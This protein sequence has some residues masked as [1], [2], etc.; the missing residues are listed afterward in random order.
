MV[1]DVAV[2]AVVAVV[3]DVAK[4]AILALVAKEADVIV[5]DELT[6]DALVAVTG[7]KVDKTIDAVLAVVALLVVT[8]NTTVG[9]SPYP[10]TTTEAEAWT[11]Y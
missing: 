6:H 7:I 5:T 11:K 9:S 3:A 1:A 10:L 8:F 4:V 2:I